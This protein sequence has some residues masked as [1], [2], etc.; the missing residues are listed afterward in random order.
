MGALDPEKILMILVIA[1]IVLGPDKLPKV[2]RQLGA[3]WRELLKFRDK[4]EREVREAMPE[5]DL[6]RIPTSP[7]AAVA[8]FLTDLTAPL[9]QPLKADAADGVDGDGA[10]A[11]PA[12]AGTSPVPAVSAPASPASRGRPLALEQPLIAPDDPS[13]N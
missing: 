5:V 8:G 4:V 13:M 2:A 6:P 1:L 9:S 10:P 7:R 12:A 3:G 11:G